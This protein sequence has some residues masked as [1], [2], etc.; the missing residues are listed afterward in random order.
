MAIVILFL[1]ALIAVRE[2]Q[3]NRERR[4]LLDRLMS[5]DFRDFKRFGSKPA[6]RESFP[7]GMNDVE[8][9]IAQ[10]RADGAKKA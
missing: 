4:D 2:W 6:A 9:A 8:M 10:H 3:N 1:C 5:A 7:P